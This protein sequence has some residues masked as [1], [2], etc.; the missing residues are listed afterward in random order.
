LLSFA[1]LRLSEDEIDLGAERWISA[2][3][4]ELWRSSI[5]S[6]P[7]R[8]PF[9]MVWQEVLAREASAGSA[10]QFHQLRSAGD[11]LDQPEFDPPPGS[12][13]LRRLRFGR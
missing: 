4:W 12:R 2:D 3:T 11:K 7:R 8:W 1:Y 9:D 10:G 6:Q 13:A 5:S